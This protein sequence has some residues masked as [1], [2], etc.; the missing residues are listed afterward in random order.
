MSGLGSA[1]KFIGYAVF[2]IGGLWGFVLDLQ[3]LNRVGG[4]LL[5]LVGFFIAP[6]TFALAPWYAG[7]AWGWWFPLILSYGAGILAVTLTAIGTS[8]SRDRRS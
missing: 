7:I 8:L 4:F 3:I 5:V 1:F 6:I 2:A